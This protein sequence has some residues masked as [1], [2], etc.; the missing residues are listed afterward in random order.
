MELK[1]YYHHEFTERASRDKFSMYN[2]AKD[3]SFLFNKR[4]CHKG[5]EKI[6]T[7]QM[8]RLANYRALD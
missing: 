6:L 2:A 5:S 7:R 1:S 3:A 8:F 4:E